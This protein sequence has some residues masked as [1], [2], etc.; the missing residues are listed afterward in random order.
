[1]NQPN[2]IFDLPPGGLWTLTE[3]LVFVFVGCVVCWVLMLWGAKGCVV[4]LVGLICF[5]G[6]TG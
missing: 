3:V 5:D 2:M 1:M 6:F 4:G